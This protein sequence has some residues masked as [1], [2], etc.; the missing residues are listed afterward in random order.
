MS[1][2]A[3]FTAALLLAVFSLSACR[4]AVNNYVIKEAIPKNSNVAVFVEGENDFKNA[5]F[6][7]FMKG[8]Y[9]VKAFNATDFYTTDDVLDV[10]ALKK[11]AFVT[12]L[13][14]TRNSQKQ[15][16]VADRVFENIYKLHIF[17]FENLKVEMLQSLQKKL[18]IRYVILLSL[19]RWDAGYTWAR[20]I[21][22]DNMQLV[23]VQNYHVGRKDDVKSVVGSMVSTMQAG[24]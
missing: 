18:G 23:Y 3:F 19:V 12:N 11:T 20:V 24:K 5:V 16:A 10:S 4:S 8:G 17:N 2:N 7:E 6:M 15:V 14:D 13:F 21:K 9:D 22:L 1:T